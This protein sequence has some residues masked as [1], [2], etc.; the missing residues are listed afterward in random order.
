[1]L[2]GSVEF[3]TKDAKYPSVFCVFLIKISETPRNWGYHFML[4]I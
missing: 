1:M 3:E 2:L 4:L